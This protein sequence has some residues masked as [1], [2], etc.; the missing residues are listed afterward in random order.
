MGT[1]DKEQQEYAKKTLAANA[2]AR[3]TFVFVH[4]PVWD[5]GPE[6]N[7][8]AAVEAALRGRKYTAFCGHRHRY[9]KYVRNGMN[10]YQLATT[11][12]ASS[13]TRAERTPRCVNSANARSA[14]ERLS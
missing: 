7:G 8:W 9:Q 14:A 3:W 1:I 6:K 13:A 5:A 11:G 12:G 10:Y 4:R 2:G